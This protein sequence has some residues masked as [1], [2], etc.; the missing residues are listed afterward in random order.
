M[1]RFCCDQLC[2]QGRACPAK[3]AQPL[4]AAHA[5]CEL[6]QEDDPPQHNMLLVVL[7]DAAMAA[8]A[9]GIACS[10]TLVLLATR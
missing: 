5:A 4:E 8:L 6:G 7:K 1:S 10:I 9:I 3:D 2:R